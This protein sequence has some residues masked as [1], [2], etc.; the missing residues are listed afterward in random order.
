MLVC[1]RC[2]WLSSWCRFCCVGFSVIC[3]IVM[4]FLGSFLSCWWVDFRVLLEEVIRWIEL[5]C[6]LCSMLICLDRF[7]RWFSMLDVLILLR[8]LRICV[9]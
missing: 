7:C 3:C 1:F 6:L 2:F 5:K 8:C 9:L 4:I